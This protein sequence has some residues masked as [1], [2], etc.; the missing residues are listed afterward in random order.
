MEELDLEL[1]PWPHLLI[2]SIIRR[3]QNSTFKSGLQL[4]RTYHASACPRP[5]IPFLVHKT[6]IELA[7]GCCLSRL[8]PFYSTAAHPCCVGPL[9]LAC[10]VLPDLPLE[11]R[12]LLLSPDQCPGVTGGSRVLRPAGRP[13]P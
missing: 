6:A 2:L 11:P 8:C 12:S 5:W 4:S 1:D 13:S 9:H 10:S 7:T 3:G